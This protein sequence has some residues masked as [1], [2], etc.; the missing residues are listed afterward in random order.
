M[1]AH[2]PQ[3]FCFKENYRRRH[4]CCYGKQSCTSPKTHGS[5]AGIAYER[6]QPGMLISI[7]QI[8]SP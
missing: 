2:R 4:K 1:N 7:N 8:E 6:D 5:E 3:N